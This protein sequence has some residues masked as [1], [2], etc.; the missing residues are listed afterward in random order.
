VKASCSTTFALG[1][2]AVS[3]ALVDCSG[4]GAQSPLVSSRMESQA[5]PVG[6]RHATG[7]GQQK[8][9]KFWWVFNTASIPSRQTAEVDANCPAHFAPSGG[10]FSGGTPLANQGFV[11]AS[12]P[13]EASTSTFGWEV[14]VKNTSPSLNLPLEAWA[15]CAKEK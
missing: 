5:L 7:S 14:I 3:L 15:V 9:G 6:I 10:G 12:L 13:Y 2:L 11:E 8:V 4:A 1:V